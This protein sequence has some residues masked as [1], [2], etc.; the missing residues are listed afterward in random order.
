MCFYDLHLLLFL[1]ILYLSYIKLFFR[2]WSHSIISSLKDKCFQ[3]FSKFDITVT[4]QN[5][6]CRVEE[7][8]MKED[9]FSSRLV[10]QFI[11]FINLSNP[12]FEP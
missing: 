3:N 5:N 9:L 11:Y 1:S 12:P 2:S 4:L 10:I 7:I 8:T 6:Q